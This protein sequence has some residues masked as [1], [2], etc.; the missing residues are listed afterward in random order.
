MGKS[1]LSVLKSE[2]RARFRRLLP[3]TRG[4]AKGLRRT[5]R[6][7]FLPRRELEEIY[8]VLLEQGLQAD[9]K[10]RYP[11]AAYTQDPRA[12]ALAIRARAAKRGAREW[13]SLLLGLLALGAAPF[14]LRGCAAFLEAGGALHERLSAAVQVNPLPYGLSLAA[15]LALSL[16]MERHWALKLWLPLLNALHVLNALL[17]FALLLWGLGAALR[18]LAFSLPAYALMLAAPAPALLALAASVPR[19]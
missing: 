5:L 19:G 10:K 18:G 8:A 17:C 3:L 11:E 13:A 4:Y 2:N 14:C 7:Y 9:A 1:S 16:N 15:F 6:A 12:Y